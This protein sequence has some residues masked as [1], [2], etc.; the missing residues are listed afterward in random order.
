L[1]DLDA[2]A[3]LVEIAF[4]DEPGRDLHQFRSELR[5]LRGLGLVIWGANRLNPLGGDILTG[6]VFEVAGRLVGC[7]TLSR[8]P[9]TPVRWLIANVAVHPDF[10]RR[11]I[12]R[13][14]VEAALAHVR[15][16]GGG[17]LVLD[18]RRENTPA[19]ALY[20]QLGFTLREATAERRWLPGAGWPRSAPPDPPAAG[21]PPAGVEPIRAADRPRVRALLHDAISAEAREAN[22]IVESEWLP[23][24]LADSLPGWM[25]WFGSRDT[26]RLGLASGDRLDAL[27]VLRA[28]RWSGTHQL[29][30][31]VRPGQ[32]T[33]AAPAAV[34]A[35]VRT[36]YRYPPLP[37]IAVLRS[38][39]DA[40][41]EAL[42]AVGFRAR[43]T[44]HR[45]ALRVF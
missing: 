26:H 4:R 30:I 19:Y 40:L 5:S 6:Y 38:P 15:G 10:R 20:E 35:A 45:L 29:Q 14:L 28:Q 31:L 42:D 7:L 37:V 24:A 25:R 34:A 23:S 17:L 22:P 27:I 2:V 3:E 8:L 43:Q 11:G 44:L 33:T 13:Q 12:A 36:L 21:T 39:A 1:R 32:E 41:I 9:G 18:V 16:R